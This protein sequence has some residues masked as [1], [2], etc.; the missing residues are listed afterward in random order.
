MLLLTEF[1]GKKEDTRRA[2]KE[3][4]EDDKNMVDVYCFISRNSWEKK[5]IFRTHIKNVKA[6]FYTNPKNAKLAP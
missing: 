4:L 6:I 2:T 3:E 1:A 5:V